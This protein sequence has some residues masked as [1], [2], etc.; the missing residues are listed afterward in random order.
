MLL[1]FLFRTGFLCC[2][3]T[4]TE[5]TFLACMFCFLISAHVMVP[6]RTVSFKCN[7]MPVHPCACVCIILKWNDKRQ[8]PW[9]TSRGMNWENKT[10]TPDF[11]WQ[12]LTFSSYKQ[13]C[14]NMSYELITRT[15]LRVKQFATIKNFS[16]VINKEFLLLFLG[17][18]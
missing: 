15:M 11:Y 14:T 3:V 17:K 18:S 9:R 6:Q 7:L 4:K 16:C 1:Q 13:I 8:I 10:Y 12:L 2:E 5:Q